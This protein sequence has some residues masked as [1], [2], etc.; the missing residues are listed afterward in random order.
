MAV[1]KVVFDG[2][3][4]LDLTGDTV[5]A[6]TLAQGYTAHDK[7]GALITGAMQSGR[8][9][10]I[11]SFNGY[12][13]TSKEISGLGFMPTEVVVSAVYS[14]LSSGL[15]YAVWLSEM[16]RTRGG[17][18]SNWTYSAT[19]ADIITPNADGFTIDIAGLGFGNSFMSL[20]DYIAIQ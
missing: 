20:Y 7:A 2:Q 4:L 8:K 12:S 14:N 18:L 19:A 15:I 1:N 11:G 13:T 17:Y 10:V 16:G 5:T 3:T 9:V 6:E